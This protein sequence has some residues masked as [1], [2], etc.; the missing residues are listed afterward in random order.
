MNSRKV[1]R[2]VPSAEKECYAQPLIANMPMYS[3]MKR[4]RI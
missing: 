4:W 1:D 2:R 3:A